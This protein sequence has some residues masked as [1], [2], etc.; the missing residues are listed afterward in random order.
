MGFPGPPS[1][2]RGSQIL[3]LEVASMDL[4]RPI[5][6]GWWTPVPHVWMGSEVD[7]GASRHELADVKC[8]SGLDRPQNPSG[9]VWHNPRHLW[10]MACEV[11]RGKFEARDRRYPARV[12]SPRDPNGWSSRQ[13]ASMFSQ[14]RIV[15]QRLGGP[16]KPQYA[17]HLGSRVSPPLHLSGLS[18]VRPSFPPGNPDD[19]SHART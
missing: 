16:P 8:R 19:Q 7:E 2:S 3:P 18:G 11:D 12:G 5:Q 4:K 10:R 9:Q 1:L 6:T 13:A 14:R 17:K 15:I